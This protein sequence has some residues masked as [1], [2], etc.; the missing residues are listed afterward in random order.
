MEAES[1]SRK[2]KEEV[3][4]PESSDYLILQLLEAILAELKDIKR[5]LNID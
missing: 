2:K 5:A 3:A 1:N 4:D